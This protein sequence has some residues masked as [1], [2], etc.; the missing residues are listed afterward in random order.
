MLETRIH[1]RLSYNIM[2]PCSTHFLYTCLF[3]AEDQ[4]GK[5]L[6]AELIPCLVVYGNRVLMDI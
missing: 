6:V 5:S 4:R 2:L 3:E 1:R